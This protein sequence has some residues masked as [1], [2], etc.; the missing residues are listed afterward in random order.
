MMYGY[1]AITRLPPE[2]HDE[3]EG[4]KAGSCE[5]EDQEAPV[6]H[7]ARARHG[8]QVVNNMR[9]GQKC[10]DTGTGLQ[11]IITMVERK[12]SVTRWL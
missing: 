1:L 10:S 7:C 8:C 11:I 6:R 4:E 3:A 5:K 2:Q 12:L 9:L